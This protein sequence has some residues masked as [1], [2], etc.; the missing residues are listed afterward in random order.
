M[1]ELKQALIGIII[2]AFVFGFFTAIGGVL[3]FRLMLASAGV[4]N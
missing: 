4:P 2:G 1:S 3:G